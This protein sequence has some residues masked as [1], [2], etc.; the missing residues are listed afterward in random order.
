MALLKGDR[1][2]ANGAVSSDDVARPSSARALIST[3]RGH[4]GGN[5]NS[6]AGGFSEQPPVESASS[7]ADPFSGCSKSSPR[8]DLVAGPEEP[9]LLNVMWQLFHVLLLLCV[10]LLM[11]VRQQRRGHLKEAPR[12]CADDDAVRGAG[13]SAGARGGGEAIKETPA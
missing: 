12:A 3:M 4:E 2:H 8:A 1:V 9:Y 7:F 6:A 13:D 10:G 11:V 5:N